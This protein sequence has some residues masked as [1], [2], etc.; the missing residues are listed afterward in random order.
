VERK[1]GRKVE[2][3]G[4]EK[5]EERRARRKGKVGGR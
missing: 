2:K 1:G 4:K 3:L 5:E